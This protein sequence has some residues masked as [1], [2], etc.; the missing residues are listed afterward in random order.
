MDIDDPS[1]DRLWRE[2][3]SYLA[4]WSIVRRPA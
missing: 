2:I 3:E 1:L 4:F